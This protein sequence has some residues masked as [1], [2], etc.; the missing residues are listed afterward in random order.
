MSLFDQ[1]RHK[2]IDEGQQKSTDMR[3][4]YIGIGHQNDFIVTKLRNIEIFMNAGTKRCDHCFD[5][6]VS[7]D[8]IQSCLFY[9]QDLTT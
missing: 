7:I 4:I 2:P 6:G 5:L 9:I 8:F 1:L 3:T